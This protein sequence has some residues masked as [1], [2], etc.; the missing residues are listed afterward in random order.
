MLLSNVSAPLRANALP[1]ELAP[2]SRVIGL[3]RQD[4]PSKMELVPSV[5]DVETC[6][7][8]FLAWVPPAGQ[9]ACCPKSSDVDPI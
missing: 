8:T 5:A 6:Q 1:A 3:E 4:V 2:V 7:K 9:P